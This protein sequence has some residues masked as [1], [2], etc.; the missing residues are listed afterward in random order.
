MKIYIP[1]SEEIREKI[2]E[3]VNT[4]LSD[5]LSTFDGKDF[6][7]IREI[8]TKE[9]ASMP[10]SSFEHKEGNIIITDNEETYMLDGFGYCRVL[11]T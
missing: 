3:L 8:T 10:I 6:I 11:F 5:T 7:F 1:K 2:V 4:E 9:F